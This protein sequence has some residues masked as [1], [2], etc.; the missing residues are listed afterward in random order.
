MASVLDGSFKN[1][2]HD[3]KKLAEDTTQSYK[4][5]ATQ[6]KEDSSIKKFLIVLDKF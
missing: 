3:I 2:V 4:E 6:F 1:D 5:A